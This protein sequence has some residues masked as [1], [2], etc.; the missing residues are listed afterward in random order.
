MVLGVIG[1]QFWLNGDIAIWVCMT[2]LQASSD[3]ECDDDS[4]ETKVG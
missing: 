2:C 4:I 1:N 3:C